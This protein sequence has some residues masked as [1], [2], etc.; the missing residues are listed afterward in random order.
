[1]QIKILELIS[2]SVCFIFTVLGTVK[3]L[4]KNTPDFFKLFVY[5][6][7]C[8]SLEELWVVINIFFG[9]GFEE[10]LISVRLFGIF[11][12]FCFTLS[13]YLNKIHG[14]RHKKPCLRALIVPAVMVI[15]Y[16][17]FAVKYL[18]SGSVFRI[19]VA[20][21][22]VSPTI[23]AAYFAVE[24]LFADADD[25]GLLKVSRPLGIITAVFAFTSAVYTHLYSFASQ[26]VLSCLDIVLALLASAVIIA[27]CRGVK[28]WKM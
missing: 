25:D 21:L 9:Y 1:M 26:L 27:A 19:A 14:V 24:S 17:L 16:V 28:K 18:E 10:G 20:Y 8:Y 11:G 6:I 2:F 12:C 13:A 15:F 4:M 3:I 7:G 5:A 23:P 22:A